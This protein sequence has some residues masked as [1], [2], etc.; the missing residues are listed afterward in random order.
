MA[1]YETNCSTMGPIFF[2]IEPSIEFEAK[3]VQI[4]FIS[5]KTDTSDRKNGDA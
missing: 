2:Q 5:N 3:Q 4:R 1:S